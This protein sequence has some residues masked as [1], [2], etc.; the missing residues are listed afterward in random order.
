MF[1]SY[2]LVQNKTYLSINHLSHWSPWF[3]FLC[4]TCYNWMT[5]SGM[6]SKFYITEG[7]IW[8]HAAF[9]N[10]V[11]P[12]RNQI[13]CLALFSFLS[14][15]HVFLEL[16]K[17]SFVYYLCACWFCLLSLPTSSTWGLSS[18]GDLGLQGPYYLQ[19][20]RSLE[21]YIQWSSF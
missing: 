9:F 4:L 21:I 19:I 11:C 3:C 17:P 1:S 14:F 13:I 5:Y 15:C 8:G 2:F 10:L 18:I 16:E 6:S 20:L 7:Q 12:L